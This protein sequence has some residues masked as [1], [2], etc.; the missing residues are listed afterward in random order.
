M[1]LIR[2][3]GPP[4]SGMSP[5]VVGRWKSSLSRA[6]LDDSVG[7]SSERSSVRDGMWDRADDREKDIPRVVKHP[8]GGIAHSPTKTGWLK[9]IQ[10]DEEPSNAAISKFPLGSPLLKLVIA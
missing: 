4:L 1:R 2:E 6:N 3:A 7:G 8:I 10:V 9:E 5:G